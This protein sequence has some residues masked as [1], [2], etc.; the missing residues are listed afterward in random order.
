MLFEILV[1][2]YYE[3]PE[4]F[5]KTVDIRNH[6]RAFQIL[7]ITTPLKLKNFENFENLKSRGNLVY[8]NNYEGFETVDKF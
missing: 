8:L 1:S 7:S 3:N 6:L 4:N 2:N 5:E